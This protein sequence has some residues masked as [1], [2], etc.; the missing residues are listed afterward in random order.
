MASRTG[1]VPTAGLTQVRFDPIILA[2]SSPQRP[3][4]DS[5]EAHEMTGNLNSLLQACS[6][7]APSIRIEVVIIS[8]VH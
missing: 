5:A 8:G 1:T 2:D 3:P 6:S 4:A 7:N